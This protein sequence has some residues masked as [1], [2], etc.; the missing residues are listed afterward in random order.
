MSKGQLNLICGK[1]QNKVE[2]T[3]RENISGI[4]ETVYGSNACFNITNLGNNELLNLLLQIF[5]SEERNGEFVVINKYLIADLL[6]LNLWNED[7]KIKL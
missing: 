5:M 3:I 1:E 7:L 4:V 6:E 2:K